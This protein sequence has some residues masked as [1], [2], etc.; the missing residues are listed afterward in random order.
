MLHF[1][2]SSDFCLG[3]ENLLFQGQKLSEKSYSI[4]FPGAKID[5][6]VK[7]AAAAG[8]AGLPYSSTERESVCS[9]RGRGIVN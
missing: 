8:G 7:E 1:Y 6:K 9:N 3:Q 5:K 4:T 2:F